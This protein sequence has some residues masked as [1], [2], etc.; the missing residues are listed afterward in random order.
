M[1]D[2]NRYRNHLYQLTQT[3][4]IRVMEALGAP[5]EMNE[6]HPKLRR[7]VVAE[8]NNDTSYAL[9]LHEMG[10]VV[11]PDGHGKSHGLCRKCCQDPM[12]M[13]DLLT[14][15]FAAWAWAREQAI[16][17]TVGMEQTEKYC[18]MS[19]LEQL[20]KARESVGMQEAA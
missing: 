12:Y 10:H 11:S 15:E 7:I 18:I 5:P 9:A 4:D 17:W 14:E 20:K 16:E 13:Y 6:A 8:I 19:Y 1:H 2:V 3:H